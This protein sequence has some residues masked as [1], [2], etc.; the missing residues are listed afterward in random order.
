MAITTML[1]SKLQCDCLVA[2]CAYTGDQHQVITGLDLYLHHKCPVV[3][4]SPEDAPADV[5]YPGIEREFVGRRAYIG[6]D[7]LDRQ[8]M[9]FERLLARPYNF[10]LL[11][12]SDS[13]CLS[14]EIPDHLFYY[15]QKTVWSNEVVEPRP[16]ASPYPKIAM[17]PPYFLS[18]P[19][20]EKLVSVA[21]KVKAHEITPYIDWAM[22]AWTYEAGL[23]HKPFTALEHTPRT[24][25]P[26]R[27]TD[28][29]EI[30]RYRIK[31][32]GT[33]FVHPIKTPAQQQLCRDAYAFYANYER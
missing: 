22:L 33:K 32:M 4:F 2:V 26:C 29:W 24:E 5:R 23:Q 16:H 14:P 12:D 19:V 3:V 18:R 28:P 13:F 10:F 15:S 25:E 17:Q 8:R 20:L 27:E 6:Q 7:S 9:H 31:F 11:H 1:R 21:D 30:L